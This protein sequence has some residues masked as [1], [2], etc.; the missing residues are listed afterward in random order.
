MGYW[1]G[2]YVDPAL[3]DL[4]FFTLVEGGVLFVPAIWHFHALYPGAY[5]RGFYI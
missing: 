2:A 5:Y 1:T 4:Y 3:I